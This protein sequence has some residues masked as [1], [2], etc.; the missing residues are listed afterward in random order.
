VF[1]ASCSFLLLLIDFRLSDVE[2]SGKFVREAFASLENS[3]SQQTGLR[4]TTWGDLVES[5]YRSLLKRVEILDTLTWGALVGDL[6]FT[7]YL[8]FMLKH[9]GYAW[10]TSV[11]SGAATTI[12]FVTMF[13]VIRRTKSGVSKIRGR[14]TSGTLLVLTAMIVVVI[15]TSFLV[16]SSWSEMAAEMQAWCQFC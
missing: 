11:I 16:I 5:S 1:G 15:G 8:L 12:L 2:D 6:A 10:W 9:Y 7:Y 3:V 14:C 13:A 4:V